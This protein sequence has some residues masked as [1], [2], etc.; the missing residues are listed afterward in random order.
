MNHLV[1]FP[2]LLPIAFLVASVS[3]L[4][5][6]QAAPPATQPP[7]AEPTQ[8]TKTMAEPATAV[9]QPTKATTKLSVALDWYPNSDHAGLFMAQAEGF[10]RDAGLDVKLYVPSNPEDALK[11]VGSGKD[12]FGIS[13][14]SDVLLAAAQGIPV[15]SVAA[16]VQHPLT[17]VITLKSSGITTPK[18]LAGKKVGYPGIP[19]QEALL[20]TMMQKDGSSIDKVELVNVGYDLVQALIGKKVDAALGAYW[21]HE[22]I[23][24]E[25]QGYP[26][27]VMRVEQW[28]VPDYYELVMVTN[29]KMAKEQSETI[30][31]F[32]G[33]TAKGY[34]AAIKDPEKA[35]DLLVKAYPETDRKM[36]EQGIRLLMPLWTQGVPV[37]GWQTKERWQSYYNWMR[38]MKL[39][40][41]DVNV[42]SVFTTAFLPK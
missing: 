2:R 13:Y 1:G 12:S 33:A 38:Q 4:A 9:A 16:L 19:G 26:V 30:K 5:A 41:G 6:C 21:T 10:Y 18:Q 17:S 34:E 25:R 22:S 42:D 39:L 24:A 11:L 40:S 20:S 28:G 31:A 27:N 35:L 14:Q 29:S 23:I 7:S 3:L 36:E 15:E 8:P 32:L 37:F